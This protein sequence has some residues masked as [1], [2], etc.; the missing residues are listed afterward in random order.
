MVFGVNRSHVRFERDIYVGS[1]IG[2]GLPGPLAIAT[3]LRFFLVA[4]RSDGR[5]DILDWR[6]VIM[7]CKKAVLSFYQK[8]FRVAEKK[9]NRTVSRSLNLAQGVIAVLQECG[10]TEVLKAPA[11]RNYHD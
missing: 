9:H 2:I 7:M 6:D 5:N 10:A 8:W 3:A 11:S 4:L 1:V